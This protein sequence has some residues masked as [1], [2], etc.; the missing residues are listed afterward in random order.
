MAKYTSD[1]STKMGAVCHTNSPPL[2][3]VV[4]QWGTH[5]VGCSSNT[6]HREIMRILYEIIDEN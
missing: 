6:K 4:T 5:L 1:L 3:R 2:P